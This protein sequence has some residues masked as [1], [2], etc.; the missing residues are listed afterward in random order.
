MARLS[1]LICFGLL[2]SIFLIN[3]PLNAQKSARPEVFRIHRGVNIS[4]WL[5]QSRARGA[6][7]QA[8]FTEADVAA[9]AEAGFD[10]IRIPI[11]EEQMWDE[12]GNKIP[13]AWQLLHAALGWMKKHRLKALVDLHIIRSHYFLDDDPPLF[14]DPA[15][16]RKFADL[17]VQLSDELKKYSRK[18]VAY[19]LLNESVAKNHDD[20]NKVYRQAY[21]AVRAREPKRVIFIGPNRWQNAR[22]FPYLTIPENDPN[23]VLSFHFYSPHI[24]T[25]YKASWTDIRDYSGPVHYPGVSIDPKDTLNLPLEIR[26]KVRQY[27]RD[28]IGIDQLENMMKVALEKADQLHLQLYCG[29]FGCLSNVGA[30]MRNRWYK[31]MITLFERHHISW[32]AWDLKS[33]GFGV[34]DPKDRSLVIP[35]DILFGRGN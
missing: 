16:Q 17:W 31:D 9:V 18:H 15:E 30:D 29:E 4:H 27:T 12:A 25:H 2:L 1:P 8:Y 20:W 11:D 24:I 19:E 10:H 14:K 5:S 7:R 13:E 3:A 21:D 35:A 23:I 34:F 32:S 26:E 6:D 22:Y 33:G 28:D